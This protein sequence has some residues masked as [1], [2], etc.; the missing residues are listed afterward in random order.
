[1]IQKI[2]LID[3]T[4]LFTLF[5]L[6]K[7]SYLVEADLINFYGLPPLQESLQDLQTCGET[8]LGYF[9]NG[10]LTGA[11]SYTSKAQEL[12]IC[13]MIVHPNHFRKGIAQLLLKELERE[14]SG[15][16]I[17]HVAT[18]RD[19]I[20][21]KKLYLKNGFQWKEDREVAP[22]FFISMFEKWYKE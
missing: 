8:F 5:Q 22:N 16:S 9:E 20:P 15:Y 1:M 13:R 21:A 4:L 18:G 2:D 12:T 7:A 17:F 10:E 19:N 11:V 6:Q 14:E 3:D